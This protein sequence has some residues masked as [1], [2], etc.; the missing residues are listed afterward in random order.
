MRSE[1]G[2]DDENPVHEVRIT[3]PFWKGKYEVTQREYESLAGSNPSHFRKGTVLRKDKRGFWLWRRLL[4]PRAS[5]REL[6]PRLDPLPRRLPVRDRAGVHVPRT[7]LPGCARPT[8]P[9][10]PLSVTF[11]GPGPFGYWAGRMY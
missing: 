1:D 3:R 7:G 6:G 4:G 11:T 9:S 5:R 2:R 10:S 8:I